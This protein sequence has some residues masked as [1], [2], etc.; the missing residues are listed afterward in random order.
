MPAG[1][2]IMTNQR[3]A[4][5]RELAEIL[6]GSIGAHPDLRFGQLRINFRFLELVKRSGGDHDGQAVQAPFREESLA[7]LRRVVKGLV[8]ETRWCP[9]RCLFRLSVPGDLLLP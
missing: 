8:S 1:E 7:T 3:Q 6:T 4:S 9:A 2:K 5:N